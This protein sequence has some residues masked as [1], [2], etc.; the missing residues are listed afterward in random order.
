MKNNQETMEA[1]MDPNHA[2]IDAWQKEKMTYQEAMV[3]YPVKVE[4]NPEEMESVAEYQE[5]PKEE[6]ALETIEALEDRYGDRR[7]TVRYHRQPKKQT[8]G[9]DGFRKKLAAARRRMTPCRSCTT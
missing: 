8:Q 5:V 9:D 7:L 2:K 3:A 4:A 1:R 6:V